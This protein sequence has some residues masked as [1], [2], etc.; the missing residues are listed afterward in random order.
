MCCVGIAEHLGCG[1]G[2][3]TGVGLLKQLTDGPSDVEREGAGRPLGRGPDPT[4]VL[5]PTRLPRLVRT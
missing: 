3:E 2:D 1:T 4:V 5:Q